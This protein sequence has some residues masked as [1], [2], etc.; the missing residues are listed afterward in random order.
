[1]RLDDLDQKHARGSAPRGAYTDVIHGDRLRS[2]VD[3]SAERGDE[4]G[5]DVPDGGRFSELPAALNRQGYSA[6]ENQFDYDTSYG[7]KRI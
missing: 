7:G 5:L 2:E 6:P 1:M 4:E 3:F